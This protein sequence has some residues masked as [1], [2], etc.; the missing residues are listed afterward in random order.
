MQRSTFL[1]PVLL[2]CSSLTVMAGATI[3]PG[4]PGLLVHFADYPNADYLARFIL[5]IPGLAIAL[6]APVAGIIADKLGRRVLLLAGVALYIVAGSAGLWVDDLIHLLLCRLLL[7]VAVGMVMV[8]SM[9]LLTDHFQGPARDRAMGIQSSSMAVGGIVFISAGAVLADVSWRAPFAVYLIP[10]VLFPLI[11][12]FV[13][14]PPG[15]DVEPALADGKFPRAHGAMIYLLAFLSMLLFY[16]IPSQLPFFAI[17][18]GAQ[19]MKYAGFAVV[20]SQVFSAVSSASYQRLRAV[21]S[22]RQILLLSF[23]LLTTGFTMLAFAQSLLMIYVSM[24]LIGIGLGFNFPNLSIW[25]MS[26]IPSTMRG[27][28]SGGLTT[29]VF[30]GQFL[31]PLISQPMVNLYGLS[32]AYLVAAMAM[33]IMVVLP[34]LV[35]LGRRSER[36]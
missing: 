35:L 13:S 16:F 6:V 14:K 28:A 12:L 2:A 21:L 34:C 27:R 7:G 26:T 24:P 5:T 18:L 4:L 9:A 22:N 17:E 23:V 8:C 31:S 10:I 20:L 15:T 1:L 32:T 19:S 36:T 11:V 25:L 3:A 33:L 29:S 30:L